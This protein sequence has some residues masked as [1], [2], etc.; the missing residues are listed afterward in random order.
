MTGTSGVF[1]LDDVPPDDRFSVGVSPAHGPRGG[2]SGVHKARS[3]S[4]RFTA[5]LDGYLINAHSLKAK[6]GG[7]GTESDAEIALALFER[8]GVQ[9]FNT[10]DGAFAVAVYDAQE[11]TLILARDPVGQMPLYYH[12]D[13][14]RLLFSSSL[15]D[16][17]QGSSAKLEMSHAALEAYL[18]LTYIPAPMTIHEGV[19]SLLAGSYMQAGSSGLGEPQTYWDIDYSDTNQIHDLAR[20]EALVRDS[21]VSSVEQAFEIS[22]STGTLLSGGI[23]STIV[24]GIAATVLG[25]TVPTFSISYRDKR[26]D[27]SARAKIAADFHHT[28]HQFIPLDF[29]EPLAELDDLLLNLDQPYADSSYLPASMV[30]RAAKQHVDTVLTGDAGDELF[31]GYSKY[32]IGHYADKFNKVPTWVSGPAIKSANRILPSG[33]DLR[34]KLNKVAESATLPPFEQRERLMAMGFSRQELGSLLLGEPNDVARLLARKYYDRYASSDDEM[35]QALY[36]DFKVVLEGDMMTKGQNVSSASGMRINI[37]LLNRRVIETAAQVPSAYKINNGVTKAIFRDT[38]S[39]LIPPELLNAPKH[40]FTMPMDV[41]LRQGLRASMLD[42]LS[43]DRIRDTKL[44]HYPAVRRVVDE[45]L[46]EREDH[47]SK[48]WALYVLMYWQDTHGS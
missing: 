41:W 30:S 37:P 28:E 44:L 9:S 16:V 13:G 14:N 29:S 48:L 11:Q 36:L 43:E 22:G 40:G 31:A 26:H 5:M 19:L 33:S 3:H 38:F 39:D 32:L 6:L 46:A 35:R 18:Q 12:Q 23:D 42:L 4:G 21:V 27:E 15:K 8:E 7:S 17:V 1:R 25:R 47:S 45:H 10:L 20:C 34:R 2:V 24:T